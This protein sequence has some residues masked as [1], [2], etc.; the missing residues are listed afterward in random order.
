MSS[1]EVEL[2][3][4]VTPAAKFILGGHALFTLQGQVARFTFKVSKKK[5][6]SD[7]EAPLFFVSVLS[8]PN[9]TQDYTC[10]ATIRGGKLSPTKRFAD[11]PPPS[12]KAFAWYF[13]RSVAGLPTVGAK[14]Y[15]HGSCCRCGRVLTTP[16]SVTSGIGP[17]CAEA[18]W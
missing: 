10:I 9:N 16:E 1:T 15:H 5:D 2:D 7:N 3:T 13:T 8:G 4:S 11:S 18:S 6:Q 14:F 17:V 12:Y